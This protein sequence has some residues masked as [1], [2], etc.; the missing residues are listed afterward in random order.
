MPLLAIWKKH[1][2]GQQVKTYILLQFV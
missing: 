2:T 1:S